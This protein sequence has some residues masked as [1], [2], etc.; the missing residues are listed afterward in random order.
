MD[1]I[2]VS[3][4]FLTVFIL[5]QLDTGSLSWI[6]E[7]LVVRYSRRPRINRSLIHWRRSHRHASP[8]S[9]Y[10]ARQGWGRPLRPERSKPWRWSVHSEILIFLYGGAIDSVGVGHVVLK[11]Q[12][13][14]CV[15][16]HL[17]PSVHVLE[18]QVLVDELDAHEQLVRWEGTSES[19]LSF[20]PCVGIK[21]FL[22]LLV[23]SRTSVLRSIAS[24]ISSPRQNFCNFI[25]H[26]SF[27]VTFL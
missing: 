1:K 26:F 21:P 22:E 2:K 18:T 25:V 16:Q 9:T 14:I 15:R 8:A 10:H 27:P 19:T 3:C 17:I 20:G 24:L 13:L 23:P 5:D 11:E 6:V 7:V 12:F 4:S